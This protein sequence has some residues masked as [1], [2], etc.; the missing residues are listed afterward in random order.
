MTTPA[1]LTDGQ[2][3]AEIRTAETAA[4]D[5]ETVLTALRSAT[6]AHLERRPNPFAALAEPDDLL[7]AQP[8]FQVD[9]CEDLSAL[10]DSQAPRPAD[11]PH[12]RPAGANAPA[13][14]STTEAASILGVSR[15]TLVRYCEDGRL[16]YAKPGKHRR[17]R[18]ADVLAFKDATTHGRVA[19]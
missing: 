4:L 8:P 12:A 7:L 3:L 9:S 15:A 1:D 14:L 16:P 2:L 17:L 19:S 13:T 10:V 6:A 5:P 18:H 11:A